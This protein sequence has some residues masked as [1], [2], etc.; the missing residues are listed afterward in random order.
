M[1]TVIDRPPSETLSFTITSFSLATGIGSSTLYEA[2]KSGALKTRL[3]GIGKRKKRII[4]KSD[5]LEYLCSF[6]YDDS[7]GE[8]AQ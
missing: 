3:L 4:M 2:A 7:A 6:P 8:S 1:D 5:G